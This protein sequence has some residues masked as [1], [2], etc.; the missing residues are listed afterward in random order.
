MICFWGVLFDPIK[1][2]GEPAESSGDDDNNNHL[3]D[4]G[5]VV[6]VNLIFNP[7]LFSNPIYPDQDTNVKYYQSSEG[8]DEDNSQDTKPERYS[9][10]KTHTYRFFLFPIVYFQRLG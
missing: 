1:S 4:I 6:V 5:H 8:D 2:H 3:G 7:N 9:M 10:F